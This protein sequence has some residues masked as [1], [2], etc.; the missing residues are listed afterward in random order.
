MQLKPVLFNWKT[1]ADGVHMGFGAQT[2]LELAEKCGIRENEL[3]AVH[4]SGTDEPWSMSYTEIV[5]L[6]VQITQKAI[7]EVENIKNTFSENKQIAIENKAK[8]ETLQE[9]IRQLY[10]YISELQTVIQKGDKKC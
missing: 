3:A 2:T 6:T 7:R 1:G 8:I 4:K 5:P 9:Q 10:V